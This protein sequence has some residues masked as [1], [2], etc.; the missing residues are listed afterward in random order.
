[1]C[2]IHAHGWNFKSADDVSF[3]IGMVFPGQESAYGVPRAQRTPG[4]PYIKA[5]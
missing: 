2:S 1:M 3:K 4:N 5:L